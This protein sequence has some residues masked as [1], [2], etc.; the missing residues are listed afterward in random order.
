MHLLGTGSGPRDT[1]PSKMGKKLE[2]R[3]KGSVKRV[4]RGGVRSFID[5]LVHGPRE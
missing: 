3:K 1:H 5:R 4:M 2:R